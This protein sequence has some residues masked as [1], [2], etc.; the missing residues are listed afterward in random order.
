MYKKILAVFLAITFMSSFASPLCNGVSAQ[1]GNQSLNDFLRTTKD[2]SAY[3]KY[4]SMKLAVNGAGKSR[5]AAHTPIMIRCEETITTNNI[6][7]GSIV[8]F[9][10]LE[11]VKDSNGRIMVKAGSPVTAQ[12]SF[13]KAK[14]M[15]GRSGE[16]T[17][18]DFH[19]TA[20]DG[21]Y[22]PLSGTV[23]AK[24][25]DKMVVSIVLSVILCPLFL[26]MSGDDAQLSAGATK[27]AYT[28]QETYIKTNA[29]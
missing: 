12:I 9:S 13:A 3:Y 8:K 11:D 24:P 25:D 27:T 22:I 29:N 4:P 10:I 5:L 17:V 19:T 1:A 2:I 26:L 16:I 18:S 6:V 15:I 7:N 28:V 20:V 14:G 23:S 21:S